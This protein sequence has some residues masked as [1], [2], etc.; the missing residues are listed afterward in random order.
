[1][2][3]QEDTYFITMPLAQIESRLI[4][5]V[6]FTNKQHPGESV[7]PSDLFGPISRFNA[8]GKEIPQKELPKE[9]IYH[10]RLWPHE[11]W[12]GRGRT[13]EVTS[14]VDIPYK[15][16]P[17]EEIPAPSEQL[18]IEENAEGVK[19]ISSRSLSK[20][21]PS[22]EVKHIINLFLEI[23]GEATM[24]DNEFKP[25]L[26]IPTRNLNWEILPPGEYPWEKLEKVIRKNSQ[27]IPQNVLALSI[28]RIKRLRSLDP[29]FEATGHAGFRGYIIFGYKKKEIYLAESTRYGNA[30]Y[31]F[32]NDWKELSKMTKADILDKD[33]QKDRII[34][35]KTWDNKITTLF[36]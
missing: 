12:A 4:K 17:R 35:D 1:M 9:T 11:E 26:E 23:F 29:D 19:F 20:D 14:I 36:S 8:N 16:Y 6:G 13:V 5:Q 18:R 15:R 32:G 2:I 25:Y 31:I 24:T 21:T 30:T 28:A 7:L 33:K 10:S 27:N 3:D 34:H 22:E